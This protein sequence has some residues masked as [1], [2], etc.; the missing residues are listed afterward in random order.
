MWSMMEQQ[1]SKTK[2]I[3]SLPHHRP[4]YY[5]HHCPLLGVDLDVKLNIMSSFIE[6]EKKV[7]QL[8][9]IDAVPDHLERLNEGI[10]CS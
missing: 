2:V 10:L 6:E 4:H 8:A 9:M 7:S 5:H 1:A 3:L